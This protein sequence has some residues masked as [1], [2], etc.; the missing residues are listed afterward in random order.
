MQLCS[1]PSSALFP[2]CIQLSVQAVPTV[3]VTLPSLASCARWRHQS[4]R[5]ARQE[6]QGHV[7]CCTCILFH[8]NPPMALQVSA[9]Y[10]R[11]CAGCVNA[12][13][14][15]K[16]FVRTVRALTT[17]SPQLLPCLAMLQAG[18]VGCPWLRMQ[19]FIAFRRIFALQ[20]SSSA[21]ASCHA[22]CANRCS[23]CLLAVCPLQGYDDACE[24]G[25]NKMIK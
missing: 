1:A 14:S 12:D 20:T 4:M 17:W 2:V 7:P 25:V 8:Y 6:H 22:L 15:A 21:R 3:G 23:P 5:A 24:H 16:T 9:E 13:T 18:I 10:D 19:D 11:V